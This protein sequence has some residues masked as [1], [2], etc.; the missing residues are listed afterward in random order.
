VTLAGDA[1]QLW[2]LFGL[3]NGRCNFA[4]QFRCK[5]TILDDLRRLSLFLP[6]FQLDQGRSGQEEILA[7]VAKG[8]VLNEKL[9]HERCVV[10]K[11]PQ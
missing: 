7:C 2:S 11:A 3:L 8:I 1:L 10:A 4:F 9:G 6:F 5:L